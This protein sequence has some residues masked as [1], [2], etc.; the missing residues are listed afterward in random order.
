M[1]LIH[2]LGLTNRVRIEY[3]G[4]TTSL[5]LWLPHKL[6]QPRQ[7]Q[8]LEV[9]SKV[10]ASQFVTDTFPAINYSSIPNILAFLRFRLCRTWTGM[11]LARIFEFAKFGFS[12]Q[13]P[14]ASRDRAAWEQ[15]GKFW[16]GVHFVELL[17]WIRTLAHSRYVTIHCCYGYTTNFCQDI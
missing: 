9:Q 12:R 17:I 4:K 3:E 8:E 7:A 11:A 5:L 13:I 1:G 15:P 10:P 14:M 2:F 6:K 16:E